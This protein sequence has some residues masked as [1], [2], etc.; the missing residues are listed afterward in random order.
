MGVLRK[1]KT[2]SRKGFASTSIREGRHHRENVVFQGPGHYERFKASVSHGTF[3]SS[4]AGTIGKPDPTASA[5]ELD[6]INL[7]HS[8]RVSDPERP[9]TPAHAHV[10]GA[11]G[12]SINGTTHRNED[13]LG[14]VRVTREL[15][16]KSS[17]LDSNGNYV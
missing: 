4:M 11:D 3:L 5:N 6:E 9:T 15:E 2:R 1:K 16:V 13:P 10:P 12:N 17:T 14:R 8:R 7:I